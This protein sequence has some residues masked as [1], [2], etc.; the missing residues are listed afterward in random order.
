MFRG[1][2]RPRLKELDGPSPALVVVDEWRASFD[3]CCDWRSCGSAKRI[4]VIEAVPA[5]ARADSGGCVSA[6]D[7][8]G[9]VV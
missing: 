5:S 2:P 9:W 3:V 1:R 8:G 6:C 7:V 4:P